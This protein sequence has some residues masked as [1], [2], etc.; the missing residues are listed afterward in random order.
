M[1]LGQSAKP[2]TVWMGITGGYYLNCPKAGVVPLPDGKD[3]PFCPACPYRLAPLTNLIK[4]D[5]QPEH[6][7]QEKEY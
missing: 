5:Q 7:I 1:A 4:T 6:D 3:T 2:H